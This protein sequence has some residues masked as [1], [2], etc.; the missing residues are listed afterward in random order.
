MRALAGVALS[1]LVLA[2]AGAPPSSAAPV[3]AAHAVA[4]AALPT[5]RSLLHEGRLPGVGD[6]Y[7]I[8]NL[9]RH[10]VR[11]DLVHGRW[12]TSLVGH[13][14]T[15][16]SQLAVTRRGV[17]W[18]VD[19]DRLVRVGQDGRQR[20]VLDL[21]SPR[22][23]F[24]TRT[25]AFL[26]VN[27]R[28]NAYVNH[29][30]AVI[31]VS[32]SGGTVTEL[33]RPT[34]VNEAPF[35][36]GTDAAGDATF[37]YP[38]VG[39]P[40]DYFDEPV[41]L[42]TFP[43]GGGAP[44]RRLTKEQAPVKNFTQQTVKGVAVA[45]SGA[46]VLHNSAVDGYNKPTTHLFAPGATTS[47]DVTTRV[48]A[49]ATAFDSRSLLYVME[50]RSWCGDGPGSQGCVADPTVDRA[51]VW[52]ASG[53]YGT[54]PVTGLSYPYGGLAADAHGRMFA[55]ENNPLYNP[56]STDV[57]PLSTVAPGGGP[58]RRILAGQFVTLTVPYG[59]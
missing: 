51:L 18:V 34:D 50:W 31:E 3:H 40:G 13:G 26:S 14:W 58:A 29:G 52:N 48:G 15:G 4:V 6:L 21:S 39:A 23:I 41:Q 7:A 57:S 5:E 54:I 49:T 20:T 37:V 10:V 19:Q 55:S 30:T 24:P 56:G 45:P 22:P 44:V 36:L 42:T 46:V 38:V 16:P 53:S 2:G 27:R 32:A 47:T 8:N 9:T 59:H 11:F 1:V 25:K 33:G 35:G 43:R 28:G 12:Q 17:A